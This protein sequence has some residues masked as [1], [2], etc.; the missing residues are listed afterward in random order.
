[1]GR[2]RGRDQQAAGQPTE[3]GV[4]R[5]DTTLTRDGDAGPTAPTERGA[6]GS[7]TR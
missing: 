2:S 7:A 5:G 1:V 4:K 3:L 6:S